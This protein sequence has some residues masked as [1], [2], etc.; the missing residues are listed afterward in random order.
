MDYDYRSGIDRLTEL[1]PDQA[2]KLR[3]TP[4][5]VVQVS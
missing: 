5:A 2:E 3:Q 1:M 4:F